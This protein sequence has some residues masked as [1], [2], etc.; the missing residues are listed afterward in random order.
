M[1][2]NIEPRRSIS[3]HSGSC[4]RKL[5]Q[6]NWGGAPVP[7]SL[8]ALCFS[9]SLREIKPS[10]TLNFYTFYMFY[11]AK[12]PSNSNSLQLQ[13]A[14]PT[15][16]LQLSLLSTRSTCSTRLKIPP[17][18]NYQLTNSHSPTPTP[19]LQLPLSNSNSL[20]FQIKYLPANKIIML[21]P[22]KYGIMFASNP[23][24]SHDKV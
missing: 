23:W 4:L 12:N 15:P 9:A 14:P 21:S 5:R 1:L 11:T 17:T 10:P 20:P 6:V 19:T 13:L 8:C 7:K 18:T 24:S 3:S 2:R 22:I 16:S